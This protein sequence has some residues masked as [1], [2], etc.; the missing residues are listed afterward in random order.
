MTYGFCVSSIT[1]LLPSPQSAQR[2]QISSQEMSVLLG[3]PCHFPAFSEKE[4]EVRERT[5]EEVGDNP[6]SQ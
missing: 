3:F 5:L 6:H 4:E 2:H 1:S